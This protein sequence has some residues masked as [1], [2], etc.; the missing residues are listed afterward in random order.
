[1]GRTRQRGAR[2]FE[3]LGQ[4]DDAALAA[5]GLTARIHDHIGASRIEQRIVALS[6]R[7]K[8]GVQALGIPLVTPSDPSLSFGVCIVAVP[9][10]QA[11]A[12]ANRL[13]AE[14]GIAGAGTGGLRL[15]PGI[16][17]TEAHV[18]RAIDGIRALLQA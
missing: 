10:G 5:L 11:G 15:C 7:L 14:Y 2:K 1:M 9:D 3:S 12:L 16:Y 8:S 6:Q 4:R 17:N 18:D 13:Y